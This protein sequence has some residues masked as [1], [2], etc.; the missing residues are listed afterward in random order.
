MPTAEEIKKKKKKWYPIFASQEFK[1]AEIGETT[2]SSPES[3]IN[4]TIEVNLMQLTNDIKKQNSIIVFKITE[5]KDDKAL[6][7]IIKL[8][9]TPSAIKRLMFRDKNK[10]EDSFTAKTK[11]N[12]KFRIKPILI[13]KAKTNRP[14]LA[15]LRKTT[16]EIVTKEASTKT[17]SEVI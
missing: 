1:Q 4:R 12:I 16:Q 17:F 10:I 13:T 3:L 2:S 8:Y 14:I 15:L 7:E 11:Y 6:T 5:V 9:L